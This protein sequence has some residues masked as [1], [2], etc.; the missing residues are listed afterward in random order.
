MGTH[1]KHLNHLRV[2]SPLDC[3]RCRH[4]GS[5]TK[6]LGVADSTDASKRM[7]C[8]RSQRATNLRPQRRNKMKNR[9]AANCDT[10]KSPIGPY[11]GTLS[12]TVRYHRTLWNVTCSECLSSETIGE[13]P[14]EIS[15][16][17]STSYGVVTSSG[18]VG[19]RNRKGRCEDAPCCGCCTF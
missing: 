16:G 10:C 7:L 11:Q 17:N 19:Y 5:D 12:R 9:F 18:W 2:C 6:R 15:K 8:L 3:G 13:R 4:S 14:L 1:E